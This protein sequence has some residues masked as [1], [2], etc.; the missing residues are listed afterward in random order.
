MAE[1]KLLKFGESYLVSGSNI[2]EAYEIFL[3]NVSTDKKG[4]LVWRNHAKKSM[5][6]L[7]GKDVKAIWITNISSELEHLQPHE[8]EQL[9]YDIEKFMMQNKRSV[10]LLLSLEYLVSFNSFK[11]ILHLVQTMRDLAAEHDVLFLAYVGV[12]TLSKQDEGLLKQ[13]LIPIVD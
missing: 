9:S 2:D 3:A 7:K 13:E 10:V 12:D 11:D 4:L 5:A 1:K 6:E 8:L